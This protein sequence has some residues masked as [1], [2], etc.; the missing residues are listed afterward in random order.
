MEV[1][2]KKQKA[3]WAQISEGR[4]EV[5]K[6]LQAAGAAPRRTRLVKVWLPRVSLFIALWGTFTWCLPVLLV[7][8]V[9]LLPLGQTTVRLHTVLYHKP[10]LLACALLVG[11]GVWAAPFT[12]SPEHAVSGPLLALFVDGFMA[13]VVAKAWMDQRLHGLQAPSHSIRWGNR[14]NWIALLNIVVSVAT[15]D[16]FSFLPFPALEEMALR[17][18]QKGGGGQGTQGYWPEWFQLPEVMPV[19]AGWVP[20]DAAGSFLNV[21]LVVPGVLVPLFG[22][23]ATSLIITSTPSLKR[24]MPFVRDSFYR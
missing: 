2:R 7:A 4:L 18:G 16:G 8:A 23:I 12:M 13:A 21:M 14:E 1:F 11:A 17:E 5:V 10:L 20:A 24:R 3:R 19:L 15:G 22:Y 6:L 9:V